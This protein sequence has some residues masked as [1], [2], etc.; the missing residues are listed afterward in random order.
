MGGLL[1]AGIWPY[2]RLF[3]VLGFASA[4]FPEI[5]GHGCWEPFLGATNIHGLLFLLFG[6][7]FPDT[8]IC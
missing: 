1:S 6:S 3:H 2:W 7:L 4:V 5:E 8:R